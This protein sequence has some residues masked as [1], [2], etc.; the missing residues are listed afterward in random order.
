DHGYVVQMPAGRRAE[1]QSQMLGSGDVASGLARLTNLSSA[2]V[3]VTV[4][5]DGDGATWG[6]FPLVP[7][8]V[9][10][11]VSGEDCF[12]L[13]DKRIT[14]SYTVGGAWLFVDI[15][16]EAVVN[17]RGTRLH[18]NYGVRYEIK[19]QMQNPGAESARAEIAIRA[20]G[21]AAWGAFSIDGDT[22]EPPLLAPGQEFVLKTMTLPAGVSR[23]IGV[24][25]MP[26][27]ASSYP[28]T[29]I[30]RSR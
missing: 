10:A 9:R 22:I 15:G 21:G 5:A 26:E 18:G 27:A 6:Y 7:P 4:S 25:T 20:G 28:V 13:P 3:K 24:R 19:V 12:F 30:I 17:R 8:E 14:A 11:A 23:T 1:I 16:R 2:A 29:L